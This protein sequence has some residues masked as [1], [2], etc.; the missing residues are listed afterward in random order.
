MIFLA[1]RPGNATTRLR[2]HVFIRADESAAYEFVLA[3]KRL[4]QP[5]S[6]FV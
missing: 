1:S 4:I 2:A 3:A 6:L 5:E